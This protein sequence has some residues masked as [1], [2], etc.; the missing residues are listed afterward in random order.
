[1]KDLRNAIAHNNVIFDTRFKTGEINNRLIDLLKKEV[2]I[3]NINFDYMD[4]YVIMITHFLKKMG[5]TK[6]SCKQFL[7]SYQ[8][9]TENFRRESPSN[10]CAQ[11][12]G[13]Q[14]RTNMTAL[15]EFI[16]S[17]KTQRKFVI[18]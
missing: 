15:R 6:T 8:S 7:T 5:E 18:Y 3:S 4:A 1:M 2:G 9:L 12:P 10:I 11:V 17:C 14:H 16:T 13:T